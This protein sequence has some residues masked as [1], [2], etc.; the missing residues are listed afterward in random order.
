MVES[1]AGPVVVAEISGNH[2]GSL[3][4]ARRLVESVAQSGCSHVKFQTYTADTMTLDCDGA[5]FR[6]GSDHKL[7]SGR[8]LYS[9]YEE[10]HTPWEWHPELF[11]L[12]RSMGLV[13]FSTPFDSTAVDFLETLSPQLYKVASLEINDIP[14]IR[15]IAATGRPIIMSTGTAT[16]SEIDDAVSTAYAAGCQDLTLLL[17][18]SAYPATP[19]DVHLARMAVLRERYGVSVG[20]S[21]HTVGIGVS[22]AAVALG[23]SVIERHVTLR[24]SDGGPDAAFSLEP[25]ELAD[26]VRASSAAAEAIGTPEWRVIGTEDE[27]RRLRRSLYMIRDCHVGEILSQDNVRSIRPAGGLEPKFLD[28]ILGARLRC[29]VPR[30]TPLSWDLIEG[31]N[32]SGLSSASGHDRGRESST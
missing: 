12:S 23:A 15:Y 13:P 11:A 10:A 21:D 9:L 24:R 28:V 17:C 14:L 27:S 20:L 8:T 3:E 1:K 30:G 19:G 4:V 2:L 18:T 25:S 32:Q 29:N 26:L 6:I 7:W 31:A 22:T 16:L 5:E